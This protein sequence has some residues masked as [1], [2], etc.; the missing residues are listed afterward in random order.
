MNEILCSLLLL[1]GAAFVL[2]AGVGVLRMPD[3]YMRLQAAT[4]ASTLGVGCLLL[5]VGIY[6]ADMAVTTRCLLI[7]GFVFLTAPVSAHV[8][9]RAAIGRA[10]LWEH[11]LIDE[12]ASDR[13][14]AGASVAVDASAVAPKMD[15]S[16]MDQDS[17]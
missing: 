9:A 15:S 13:R 5:G 14:A 16:I 6:D 7:A 11:S 1:L 12:L 3:I 17:E 10:Q 4:K 2:L 8:M